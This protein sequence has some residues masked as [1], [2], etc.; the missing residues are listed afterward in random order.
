MSS[1]QVGRF[2]R[3]DE[4][5]RVIREAE[6]ELHTLTGGQIPDEV[7]Q[8]LLRSEAAQ[9]QLA[10]HQLA[11]LNALPAHIALIDAEGVILS[12][13]EA[14]LRFGQANVLQGEAS[15]VGLNYLSICDAA[16]GAGSEE[17]VSAAEGIRR[18]LRGETPQFGLEYPC[19]S[20]TERRWFR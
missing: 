11:I 6:R 17:T 14:W 4:L 10:E 1:D 15:G 20:P 13:N 8:R 19:H 2:S 3:I 9:R 7:Q 12:V 16:M 18:V 5:F